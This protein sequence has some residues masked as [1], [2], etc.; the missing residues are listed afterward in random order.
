MKKIRHSTTGTRH[1]STMTTPRR[2]ASRAVLALIILVLPVALAFRTPPKKSLPLTSLPS[3]R[4]RR[5]N[6]L[7]ATIIAGLRGGSDVPATDISDIPAK[8]DLELT[9]AKVAAYVG[10]AALAAFTIALVKQVP[11]SGGHAPELVRELCANLGISELGATGLFHLGYFLHCFLVIA[12]M[13]RG[14]K[15]TVFSPAGVILLGTVFP[16]VESIKA[17]ARSREDSAA[18]SRTWLMYWVMHGIFSFASHDMAK[19]IKRF[20]PR[21]GKHWYEF[22]FYSK[23]DTLAISIQLP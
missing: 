1:T 2:T 18:T 12:I 6:N 7:D 10:A 22:Q 9:P 19:V 11:R 17:A 8:F 20:G 4:R 15:D 23:L 3:A 21:G 13:P 14:L 16:L 5:Y